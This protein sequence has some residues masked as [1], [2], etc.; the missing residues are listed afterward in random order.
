M[1][2]TFSGQIEYLKFETIFI[3]GH[4]NENIAQTF[5]FF[6]YLIQ[7]PINL[8]QFNKLSETNVF[9][10]LINLSQNYSDKQYHD[11]SSISEV[12]RHLDFLA[13]SEGL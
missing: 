6:F 10:G 11:V 7:L 3:F 5:Q 13:I 1:N 2:Y 4:I 9:D 12:I 8:E